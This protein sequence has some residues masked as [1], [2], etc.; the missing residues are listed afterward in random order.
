MSCQ[1]IMLLDLPV[2]CLYLHVL[3]APS[4]CP[5]R[6]RLWMH[7]LRPQGCSNTPLL[8]EEMILGDK[9]T[10][11]EVR[12]WADTGRALL[13]TGIPKGGQSGRWAWGGRGWITQ[14]FPSDWV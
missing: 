9:M 13:L 11:A 10:P 4:P 2:P 8:Q 3:F 6:S 7:L 14:I 12:G 5:A 1:P